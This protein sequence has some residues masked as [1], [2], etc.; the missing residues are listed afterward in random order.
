ME[1]T[2]LTVAGCEI[3]I[4]QAGEGAPLLFLHPGGGFKPDDPYVAL[5]AKGRKLICPSHPGFGRSALPD[6]ID[7]VDDIAHIYLELMDRLGLQKADIVGCSIGGWITAEMATKAPERFGKI[8]F[9]APVGIKTGP[10]DTLDIPDIFVMAPPDVSK[11][12]FHDPA[13]F[14]PDF[15]KMSDEALQIMVRNREALALFVWEPYMHNPKL[16]HR[17]QRIASPTLFLRGGSDGLV[18]KKYLEAYAGLVAGSM[19]ET[20]PEAGH[21]LSVE[22]PQAFADKINAFLGA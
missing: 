21:A 16:K 3:E 11:L 15:S 13:K 12:M 17:L 20:I 4:H 7:S 10:A 14:T 5:L 18:S 22:Q 6:W 1:R 8:V 2:T 9:V 19:I